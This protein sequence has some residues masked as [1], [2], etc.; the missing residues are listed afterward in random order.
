MNKFLHP[1]FRIIT[2]HLIIFYVLLDAFFGLIFGLGLNRNLS[3]IIPIGTVIGI[4]LIYLI[5]A[6]LSFLIEYLKPYKTI[7]SLVMAIKDDRTLRRIITSYFGAFI[8]MGLSIYYLVRSFMNFTLINVISFQFFLLAFAGRMLLLR[9]MFLN[10]RGKDDVVKDLRIAAI[11]SLLLGLNLILYASL[12]V[13]ER[14]T[15]TKNW[16]LVYAYAFYSFVKMG[17]AVYSC[18]KAY[19]QRD[20]RLFSFTLISFALA[21]YSIF[22]L[23]I[24][25]PASL[26]Q[27]TTINFAYT[28]FSFG[29]AIIVISVIC[30]FNCHRIRKD[31]NQDDSD[32]QT[33]K[34]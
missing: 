25:I 27:D 5:Y 9:Q 10:E 19:K 22:M 28:G 16:F 7:K 8:N 15:I 18:I 2:I 12:A 13:T 3:A 23:S 6:V 4:Y 29:A 14:Y 21:C 24:T 31:N 20:H 32:S 11:F 30:L 26:G 1:D 17:N 33:S 34:A